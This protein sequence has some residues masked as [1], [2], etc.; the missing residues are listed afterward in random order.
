MAR[1]IRIE[2]AGAVYHVMARGNQGQPVFADD[3]DR[4]LWLQ[5]L[6]ETCE[7]TGWQIHAYVL[8]TNHYHLLLETPEGNLV[9]GMKWLQSTYTQRYNSRHQVCGH[10]FQ[11]RYKA[12][13]VDGVEGNYFGVVSTYIH[14]NPARAKL[15][16]VGKERLSRYGWSSYPWYLKRRQERPAWL[17]TQRVLG[18]LGLWAKDAGGYEAYLE[19]RVLELGMKEGR[20]ELDEE[21]QRIRRGW[22]LGGEGFR[23]RLL[24]VLKRTMAQG[25]GSSY[26]GEA[27]RA[28]GEAEAQRLLTRGLAV[29]SL[30]PGELGWGSKSL[31]EKQVLAWYLRQRTAVSRRWISERLKMGEESGVTRAVRRVKGGKE[32]RME[33]IKRR[34]LKGLEEL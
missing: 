1:K 10:L 25:Q 4:N 13:V 16:R 11:G 12:L 30:K 6:G 33:R 18:D 32:N 7:K 9:A 31:R 23:G 27:K 3:L 29:L 24:K 2:Y 21:W 19:G 15:I 17:V 22:Y 34:L 26:G 28:H 14:L 8:M 5:T 20:R